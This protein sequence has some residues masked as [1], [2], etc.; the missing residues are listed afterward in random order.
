MLFD[1]AGRM[2]TTVQISDA[3]LAD[4][5]K[6][7]AKRNTTLKTLVDEGLRLV[8]ANEQRTQMP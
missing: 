1:V 6:V 3:L 5:K 4:V 8:V 2:K 7:A